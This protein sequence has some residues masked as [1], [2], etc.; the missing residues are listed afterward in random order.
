MKKAV[1]KKKKDEML[2]EYNF[3]KGVRAKYFDRQFD[4]G[5]DISK[6]LDVSKA[7]KAVQKETLDSRSKHHGNDK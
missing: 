3:S 1:N 2:D 7:R 5:K 6:H 4:E